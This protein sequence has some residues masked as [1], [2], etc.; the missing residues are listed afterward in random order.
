MSQHK[1][2]E[3]HLT[4]IVYFGNQPVGISLYVEDRA[5]ASEIG[6]GEIVARIDE[7]LPMSFFSSPMPASQ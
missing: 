4:R 6:M 3:Q 2:N 7:A 1:P 5:D